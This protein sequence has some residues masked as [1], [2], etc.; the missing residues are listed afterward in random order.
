MFILWL[1]VRE[2]HL[3]ASNIR[4]KSVIWTIASNR[5]RGGIFDGPLFIDYW[6]KCFWSFE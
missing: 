3:L 6:F 1:T 5:G 2:L 4:K